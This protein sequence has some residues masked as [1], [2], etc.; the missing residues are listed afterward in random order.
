M[1]AIVLTQDPP[2][3][4]AIHTIPFYLYL[5]KPSLRLL[6]QHSFGRP[7]NNLIVSLPLR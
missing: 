1:K 3:G 2:L 5:N 4:Y 7:N 6:G